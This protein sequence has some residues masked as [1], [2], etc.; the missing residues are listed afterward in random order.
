MSAWAR[1]VHDC[2]AA[3]AAYCGM[4]VGQALTG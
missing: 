2:R 3:G 4:A 1:L